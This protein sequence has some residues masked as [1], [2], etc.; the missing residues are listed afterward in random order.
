MSY[1]HLNAMK[2]G[3]VSISA[4]SDYLVFFSVTSCSVLKK[5]HRK[6]PTNV[7][8]AHHRYFSSSA[9]SRCMP[10]NRLMSLSCR[11]SFVPCAICPL[12]HTYARGLIL[13]CAIKSRFLESQRPE[14]E[15]TPLE[16]QVRGPIS[17]SAGCHRG[18]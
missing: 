15:H 4:N 9:P 5:N 13:F 12:W 7:E 17:L 2:L 3:P 18:R 8:G 6:Q 11:C 14:R 16:M 10:I 1:L